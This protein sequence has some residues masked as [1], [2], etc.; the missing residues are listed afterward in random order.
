[1]RLRLQRGGRVRTLKHQRQWNLTDSRATTKKAGIGELISF[2]KSTYSFYAHVNLFAPFYCIIC[3]PWSRD[4]NE[5]SGSWERLRRDLD[6]WNFRYFWV[7]LEL[8]E[9]KPRGR[10]QKVSSDQGISGSIHWSPLSGSSPWWRTC[11]RSTDTHL[12]TIG[13]NCALEWC[14][15]KMEP[16]YSGTGLFWWSSRRSPLQ[17]KRNEFISPSRRHSE[18]NGLGI[19][20]YIVIL[21]APGR[22]SVRL[23]PSH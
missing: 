21:V 5:K 16:L 6:A 22:T 18:L 2:I 15:L 14:C 8:E 20:L 7:V 9:G 10:Q 3:P 1:M 4:K 19:F 11:E 23:K 13:A 12:R 17:S